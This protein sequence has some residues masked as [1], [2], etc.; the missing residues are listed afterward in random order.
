MDRKL[1]AIVLN[2]CKHCISRPVCNKQCD[3]FH[4]YEQTV[5]ILWSISFIVISFIAWWISYYLVWN[6]YGQIP[7]FIM[8]MII[9]IGYIRSSIEIFKDRDFIF[10]D[11][12]FK[13]HKIYEKMLACIL[14]PYGMVTMWTLDKIN[15]DYYIEKYILY[16]FK[17][18][19]F[20]RIHGEI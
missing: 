1:N 10:K 15:F 9:T 20:E 16:R 7:R 3:D 6:N 18:N 12:D 2:P 4:C 13:D 19:L 8:T 5:I 14:G 11:R 17:K